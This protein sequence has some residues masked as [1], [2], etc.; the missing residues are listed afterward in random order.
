[1]IHSLKIKN[2]LSFKNETVF[3]FEATKD[4]NLEQYHIVEIAPNVRLNKLGIVYGA[5]A[6]GKSNLVKAFSFMKKFWLR[7]PKDKDAGTKLIP[8]LLDNT[9]KNKPAEFVLTFY[10]DDKKFIYTLNLDQKSVIHESLLYYP[11]TQPA[12]IFTRELNNGVSEI[13][14]NSKFKLSSNAKEEIKLK[15]LPNVSIFAAY[16]QVNIGLP[17]I[18]KVNAWM[19]TQYTDPII[20]D[21]KLTWFAKRLILSDSSKKDYILNFLNEAD[22]NIEDLNLDEI[23]VDQDTMN[24]L[25]EKNVISNQIKTDLEKGG[26]LIYDKTNFI[27][28][29]VD[30]KG[31]INLFELPEHL[32]S[33]GTIRSIGLAGALIHIIEKNAFTAID[34]IESSMHP[35][36]IEFLIETFLKQSDRAQLLLCTHYDG[37]LN[38]SDLLRNDNIWFT[39][40]NKD[41]STE[42]YS[43]SDFK[44]VNRIS[45]LQ[46]A[47]KYGKFGAVPNI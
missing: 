20:P 35:K 38:Q 15:C 4:K 10:I 44:G 7:K 37:L 12:E 14:F 30:E 36:L 1:M 22:Y 43:L 39:S 9:S 41:G 32:Q 27:H 34:E 24:D 42:L 13:D 6:S 46:K 11:G 23:E 28:K 26:K 19:K 25:I 18:E 8:F 21:T 17:L 3:S 5:N 16:N 33:K 47:Y 31:K 40:K 29:V 45:S 2:F